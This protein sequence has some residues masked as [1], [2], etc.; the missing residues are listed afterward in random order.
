M[1]ACGG[2][3]LEQLAMRQ[4]SASNIA[5]YF[6]RLAQRGRMELTNKKLQKLL[7]FAQA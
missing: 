5:K 1:T 2:S 6:V 3:R 7:Y 4:T